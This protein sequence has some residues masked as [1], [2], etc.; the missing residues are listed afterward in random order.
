[1][2][3]GCITAWRW[4]SEDNSQESVPPSTMYA[5]DLETDHRRNITRTCRVVQQVRGLALRAKSLS[6]GQASHV[7]GE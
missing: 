4:R 6:D 3:W 7:M 1:M 5:P 2:V